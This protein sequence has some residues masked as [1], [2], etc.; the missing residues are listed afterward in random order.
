MVRGMK[1]AS[2]YNARKAKKL[3]ALVN[4]MARVN[5]S[6]TTLKDFANMANALAVAIEIEANCTVM[7]LITKMKRKLAV[8][9]DGAK[10]DA[11]VTAFA[12][13][14]WKFLT[15]VMKDVKYA[16]A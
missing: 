6:D 13:D 7:Q 14:A 2:F 4:A 9:R 16:E 3:Y 5:G 11:V 12:T 10:D 15:G 8:I 1:P